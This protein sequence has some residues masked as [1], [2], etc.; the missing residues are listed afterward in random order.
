[1]LTAKDAPVI[2]GSFDVLLRH[3][4]PGSSAFLFFGASNTT[5]AGL[6]LPFDMSVA[7]AGS[8]CFINASGEA[9]IGPLVPGLL[10]DVTL[11]IPVPNVA[12][13]AGAVLYNQ[14]VSIDTPGAAL[15][16]VFS[17]G[18]KATFGF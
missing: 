12:T 3:A 17:N 11:N 8:G 18:G 14:W 9:T 7:G 4:A 13:L 15:P 6:P 5:W 1:M 2:G 16:L 10:G